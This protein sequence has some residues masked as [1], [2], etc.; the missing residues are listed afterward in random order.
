MNE[1]IQGI[2]GL[3]VR[4]KAGRLRALMPVI[5]DRLADGVQQ[6]DIITALREGGIDLTPGTFKSYL[7]RYR[8]KQ[9]NHPTSLPQLKSE[10]PRSEQDRPDTDLAAST[11]CTPSVD[12][13]L[14]TDPT[15]LTPHR[16]TLAELLDPKKCDAYLDQYM[17][18][19]RPLLRR[20]R[21]KS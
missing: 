7:H 5:E 4:T 18:S 8:A 17:T 13:D 12:V 16:L 21:D 20:N 14:N 9:R 6:Q 19:S 10:P 1:L 2:R 15:D 11:D 3:S